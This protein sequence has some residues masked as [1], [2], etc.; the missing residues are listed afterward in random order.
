MSFCPFC[1]FALVHFLAILQ[2]LR[3]HRGDSDVYID[4]PDPKARLQRSVEGLLGAL[5]EYATAGRLP[6]NERA[7]R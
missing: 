1:H 7:K 5:A 6:T 2:D 4:W 3:K